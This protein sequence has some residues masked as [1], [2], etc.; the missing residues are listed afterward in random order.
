ML[1]F[2]QEVKCKIKQELFFYLAAHKKQFFLPLIL[3]RNNMP[4]IQKHLKPYVSKASIQM[5]IVET[6]VG[7]QLMTC[8]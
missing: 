3:P 4:S 1:I 2:L 7:K 8:F 5:N 6:I